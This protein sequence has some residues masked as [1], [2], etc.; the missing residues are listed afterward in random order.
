MDMRWECPESSDAV[1]KEGKPSPSDSDEPIF[2]NELEDPIRVGGG[3]E[4]D[5]KASEPR[6]R[7]TGVLEPGP[8]DAGFGELESD[9]TD[10]DIRE[11]ASKALADLVAMPIAKV[12]TAGIRTLE[13]DGGN[14]AAGELV[15]QFSEALQDIVDPARIPAGL[16]EKT[17]THL[18]S[19]ATATLGPV[20]PV[21]AVFAG[22]F[23]G[24]L[25]R[26][27][28]DA[29]RDQAGIESAENAIDLAD[30]FADARIGRLAESEPFAEYLTDLLGK[31]IEA[32]VSEDASAA[33]SRKKE[34]EIGRRPAITALI[35]AYEVRVPA[36]GSG[37]G[38]SDDSATIRLRPVSV[39]VLD[40]IPTKAVVD[41]WRSG[42]YQYLQLSDGTVVRRHVLQDH[43][44][45]W[46]WVKS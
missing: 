37:S 31:P 30:A 24:E 13:G 19:A 7:D 11:A 36:N 45:P 3:K 27:V 16:V 4:D 28:L 12:T 41:R 23:A 20:G 9:A 43:R 26:Q 29:N 25:T 10:S 35:A 5:L 34:R 8:G 2:A 14:E 6:L 33:T 40:C 32:I 39:A 46:V 1:P 21:I 38:S 17:V 42:S 22:K 15:D 18:V 44:G